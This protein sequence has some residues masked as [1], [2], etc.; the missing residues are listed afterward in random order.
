MSLDG[1]TFAAVLFDNDGTLVDSAPAATRAWKAW[2]A[3]HDIALT[4]LQGRHGLPAAEI[5]RLVA[6]DVDPEAGL[7]RIIELEEADTD[8]VVALPGAA[9][10]VSACGDRCAVVTSATR[11]LA[12]ARLSAAGIPEPAV[13]VTVEDI[14]RGKPDPEPFQLGASRL[15]VD[16][17]D[18]L[19]V[20][21]APAGLAAA[22]AAG[23]ARLAVVTTT[24]PDELEA[25]LVVPDLSHVRF[26]RR[27]D[28]IAVHRT[29]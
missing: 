17:A 4:S 26:E 1:R 24:E 19:V 20:E 8:G 6:P 13:L 5:V 25:D 23:A 9:E 2:A 14:S 12:Q 16:P 29:A 7:A 11:G 10:A 3:E 22:A 27:G 18:C 28:R 21:D 15:G